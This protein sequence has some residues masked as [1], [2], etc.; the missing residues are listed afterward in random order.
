MARVSKGAAG[1]I[2]AAR[3]LRDKKYTILAA[4]YRCRFGE[5]DIIAADR[6]YIT[7]VEVKTRR[8]DAMVSPREA[9]TVAKRRRVIQTAAMYLSHY[10]T[11]LQ[12]RFDVIE[13]V[14]ATDDPL[15]VVEIN[16]IVGAYETGDLRTAF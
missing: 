10:P 8:N 5:V 6:S 7:F 1:E 11:K 16:H 15:K 4:N 14:T 12:P 3:F 9:V 2:V 13:V